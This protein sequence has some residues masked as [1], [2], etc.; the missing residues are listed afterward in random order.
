MRLEDERDRANELLQETRDALGQ[1]TMAAAALAHE[2][3]AATQARTS[4]APVTTRRRQG[5][6]QTVKTE[7]PH[8]AH[9]GDG[10]RDLINENSSARAKKLL[11]LQRQQQRT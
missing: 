10:H 7:S 1:A 8:E 11:R 3:Q 4:A 6:P 9:A 5:L 2:R